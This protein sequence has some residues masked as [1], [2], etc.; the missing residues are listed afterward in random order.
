MSGTFGGIEQASSALSAARYALDVVSQ[1]IANANTPGYTRQVAQQGSVDGTGTVPSLYTRPT[2]LGGVTVTGTSRMNDPV[3]DARARAEHARGALADATASQLSSVEDVF[4]EPADSGLGAQ[5]GDFWNA[6]SSVANAVG[7]GGTDTAA[8]E[9]LLAKATTVTS[10]LNAMD[11]SLAGVAAAS[12][13]SL[14][15]SVDAANSAATQ[16]ANVNGQIAVASA[17]GANVNS[18][19]DQRD[20]ILGQLSTLVGGV[21]TIG[22][23]GA[24]GVTVG[25]QSLVS[26][27]TTTALSVDPAYQ[28]SVGGTAVTLTGGS[29]AANATALTTTIPG[30][31]TRLDG[32]AAALGA[33]VNAVQAAG[34][35]QT[36]AA[37][38]PMFSGTTAATIAVAIT[39]PAGIA[40]ASSAG[41]VDGSNAQA[42]AALGTAAGGPDALYTALVGDVGSASALATQQQT[43]Q[44]SVT[45][46]VDGLRTSASGVSYDE[47]VSNM[48]T[49]QRAYQAASRVLTT[50]DDML[51][52]LINKTGTVGR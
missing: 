45:A 17:T 32:V 28:V 7:S 3:L 12:A 50:V 2:G 22:P 1:N 21:A 49:Y 25:G 19:L 24:A 15:Q 29:A 47:E 5:L 42:A 46:T 41:T 23:N 48:L 36:G 40:A 38:A 35:D 16:L 33:V 4:P 44:S 51:D 27:V 43:T 31:Q 11:T 13:Q 34:Q 9:V 26:G 37:G 39:D 18:L 30:Y 14:G 6:W 10:T 52:T 20:Q 8:R